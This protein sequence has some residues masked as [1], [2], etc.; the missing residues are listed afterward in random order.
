[1]RVEL[2]R[3]PALNQL[4]SHRQCRR[5]KAASPP[6]AEAEPCEEVMQA[7]LAAVLTGWGRGEGR[8]A[9]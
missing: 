1:M 3:V 2:D 7:A 9:G 6:W 4:P 5:L 8:L